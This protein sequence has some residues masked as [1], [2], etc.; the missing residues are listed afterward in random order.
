MDRKTLYVDVDDTLLCHD[1]SEFSYD[2]RIEVECNG[3]HFLG[4][5]HEKNI[6]LMKKFYR[7]G[8]DCYV[9]SKTGKSWATAVVNALGLVDY[10]EACL[11][12]PDFIMDDK[13]VST[14]MGTRCWRNPH[15]GEEET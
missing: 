14:W 2:K 15:S 7:L 11:S 8:Y 12:K 9:W 4:V 3:R 6:K 10:V 5:P 1:L 13:D